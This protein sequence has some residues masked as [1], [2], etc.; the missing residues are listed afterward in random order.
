[1]S[2]IERE[3]RY[4]VVKIKHLS[5]LDEKCLRSTLE[6]LAIPTQECVVVESDWPCYE[7]V[8]EIVQQ[9]A[10]GEYIV[11]EHL[12]A[13]ES[14]PGLCIHCNAKLPRNQDHCPACG[15]DQIPF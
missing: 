4:I 8:W 15:R 9:V 1:M 6:A 11:P 12:K 10:E 7:H 3:E 5:D 2:N 14:E 13:P